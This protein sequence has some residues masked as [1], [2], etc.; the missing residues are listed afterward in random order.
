MID[1]NKLFSVKGKVALVTGGSRGI[2]LMIAKGYIQAG[3][4]VYISSRNSEVCN[5][6]SDELSKTGE[7]IPIPTDL[8]NEEGVTLLSDKIKSF[9]KKLDILVNNAG[10]TWGAPLDEYPMKSWEMVMKVNVSSP[11]QLTK[12]L[13]PVLR[14]AGTKED[15]ARVINIGSPAGSLSGGLNAYAY[16]TSKA[17]LHHLTRVLAKDLAKENINVNTISPGPFP[18]KMTDFKV[19][20]KTFLETAGGSTPQGRYGKEQDMVA[21][22]LFL[23]G[24]GSAY[25]TGA[26]IPLDGGVTLGS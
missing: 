19:G 11:F 23:S 7:C 25:I 12:E 21:T 2:G 9:E 3:A 24:I 18:S 13:L 22:A 26:L 6:V 5:E 14:E 16:N 8:S 1:N 15:P 20:E 4:K 17:A 10:K